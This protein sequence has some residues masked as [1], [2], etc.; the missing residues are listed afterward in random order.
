MSFKQKIFVCRLHHILHEMFS[1]LPGNMQSI[2]LYVYKVVSACAV[3]CIG[4]R[5]E[6]ATHIIARSKTTT[7]LLILN[8]QVTWKMRHQL[9]SLHYMDGVFSMLVWYSICLCACSVSGVEAGKRDNNERSK[10]DRINIE[11]FWSWI[12]IS[13]FSI[14]KQRI[15]SIIIYYCRDRDNSSNEARMQ[16]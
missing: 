16:R 14:G 7:T 3:R 5:D 8:W 9:F 15:C 4:V 10:N 11:H 6:S 2:H 13:Q 1:M 12:Q